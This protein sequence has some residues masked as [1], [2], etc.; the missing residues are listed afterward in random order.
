[1]NN[2]IEGSKIPGDPDNLIIRYDYPHLNICEFI[3]I[4]LMNP[5]YDINSFIYLEYMNDNTDD[6]HRVIFTFLETIIKMN[7]YN[8]NQQI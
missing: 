5:K 4:L 8:D 1:M 3:L 2:I 7:L 6:H